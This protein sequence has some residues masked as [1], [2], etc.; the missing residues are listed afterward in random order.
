[1]AAR[2]DK[3][4][5]ARLE[6]AEER[7]LEAIRRRRTGVERL[8][9]ALEREETLDADAIARALDGEPAQAASAP[10]PV[11]PPTAARLEIVPEESRS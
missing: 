7:A 11:R 2:V 1:M 4:V 9:D 5:A 8:I 6:E 10:E 3:A